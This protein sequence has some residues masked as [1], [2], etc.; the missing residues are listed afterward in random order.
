[1]SIIEEFFSNNMQALLDCIDDR[2]VIIDKSGAILLMNKANQSGAPFDIQN[3]IGKKIHEFPG[4][5]TKQASITE[6]LKIR[7]TMTRNVSYANGKTITWTSVPFFNKDGRL[8]M[9][10]STGRDITQFIELA[11]ELKEK[12]QLIDKHSSQLK[13]LKFFSDYTDIIYSSVQMHNVLNKAA[14]IKDMDSPVLIWGET[15]VGKEMI[16]KMIHTTGNRK[17]KPFVAIN[18]AAIPDEL[19]ESELFG[20]EHGSFSGAKR[21]GKKGLIEEAHEG[22]L[23]LD[24]IGELPMKMQSKL[25]RFLQERKFIRIGGNKEIKANVRII[26]ATNLTQG[27]LMNN[28]NFRRDLFY[29]ISVFPIIVPALKERKDDIFPLMDHFIYFF[30]KKYKKDVHISSKFMVRLYNHDWPCN[31]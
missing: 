1:M 29:R 13:E 16:A 23:F 19:L 15:G 21:S 4:L 2:V 30:N 14:K 26:C 27:E 6:I 8:A 20:Y 11:S 7:Q 10:I 24:E 28:G 31:I 9:L 5:T 25:L 18:C 3:M 12:E 22:I 17:D